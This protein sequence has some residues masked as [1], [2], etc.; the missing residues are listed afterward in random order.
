M[1]ATAPDDLLAAGSV[2]VAAAVSE[3]FIRQRTVYEMMQR[4]DLPYS[5]V[6]ARRLIPRLALRRLIA[7]NMV[8]VKDVSR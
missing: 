2:T 3:F 1:I 5:M 7:E 8:D 6:G 4:G